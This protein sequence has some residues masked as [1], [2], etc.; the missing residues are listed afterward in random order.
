MKC[1]CRFTVLEMKMMIWQKIDMGSGYKCNK[2]TKIKT[3]SLYALYLQML[4]FGYIIVK[5]AA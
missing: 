3:A 1:R 2:T 4:L 5:Y